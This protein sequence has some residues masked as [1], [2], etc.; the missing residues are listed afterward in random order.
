ML[1]LLLLGF[2]GLSFFCAFL[3]YACVRLNDIMNQID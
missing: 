3:F 2:F 1:G